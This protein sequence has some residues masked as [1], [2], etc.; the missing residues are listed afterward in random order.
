MSIEM[1]IS[2]ALVSVIGTLI[3]RYLTEKIYTA[4]R[5]EVTFQ[6][7][8]LH[9]PDV[10]DLLNKQE[11][12]DAMY[13]LSR[14]LPIEEIATRINRTRS[15]VRS[16]DV[17]LRIHGMLTD[18]R[19]G[20]D[21]EALKM[22]KILKIYPDSQPMRDQLF[23]NDFFIT[24]LVQAK[25]NREFLIAVYT[26]PEEVEEKISG[27]PISSW[28]YTFSRFTVP[29]FKENLLEEFFKEYNSI[30]NENPFPP[31][32]T[33]IQ[34]IDLIYMYICKWAQ[35][36]PEFATEKDKLAS[37]I[38]EEIGDLIDVSYHYI[39]AKLNILKENNIL[40]PINPLF[41]EGIN[42]DS[43]ISFINH[44]E[45]YRVIKTFN[46]FNIITALCFTSEGKYGLWLHYPHDHEKSILQILNDLDPHHETYL[47]SDVLIRTT[48]PYK[49]FVDKRRGIPH[50]I[51]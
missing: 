47:L 42:Y 51:G 24:Y 7:K 18:A 35:I 12:L 34:D 21:T 14:E 33:P 1:Y 45:V 49:Y 27:I 9:D 25:R 40:F 3:I 15:F 36:W 29:F 4:E 28:Y 46:Q 5:K 41:L 22:K 39:D 38:E 11:K 44:Q 8:I 10:R 30:T 13:Y 43:L 6:G 32:G 20:V 48:I 2:F 37:N 16:I 23:S 31:R 50:E 19:W 26:I 17:L